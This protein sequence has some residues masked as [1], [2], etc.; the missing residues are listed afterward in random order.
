MT[1]KVQKIKEWIQTRKLCTMDEHMKFYCKE[2][3]SDY[4]MLCSIEKVLDS[5]QEEPV[6][7]ELTAEIKSW[8]KQWSENEMEWSREDIW[9]T[10]EHFANWQKEQLMKGAEE[11]YIRRNRYTKKNVLNG[12]DVTCDAI[13]RLKG[14]DKVKVI[15]IKED[16]L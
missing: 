5:L 11:C 3:E 7:K 12:F 14:G 2:A 15:V 9:D 13:Q 1:D 8:L 16:L 4:N 10:A 6:S